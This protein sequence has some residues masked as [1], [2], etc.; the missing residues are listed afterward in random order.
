MC[1]TLCCCFLL[2]FDLIVTQTLHF[3]VQIQYTKNKDKKISLPY[4]VIQTFVTPN[5]QL[6]FALFP[7]RTESA[8]NT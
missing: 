4:P 1:I 2:L 7:K 3:T 6:F 8:R 5:Q